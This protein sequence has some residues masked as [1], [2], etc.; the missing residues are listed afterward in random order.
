MAF[1]GLK[2][3]I[4]KANQVSVC[5]CVCV[6]GVGYAGRIDSAHPRVLLCLF[7]T[8]PRFRFLFKLTKR[9][10][11]SVFCSRVYF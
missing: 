6:W 11:R 10:R 8:G 9:R 1:A 5:V 7:S 4:N 3:Q 2:K